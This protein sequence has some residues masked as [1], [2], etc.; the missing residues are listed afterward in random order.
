MASQS[1]GF[2]RRSAPG[3]PLPSLDLLAQEQEYKRLNAELEAKTADLI[4][5]AEEAIRDQHE[6]QSRPCSTLCKSCEEK[7]DYSIRSPLSSE[8]I[9][10]LHPETKNR[11]LNS[12]PC[13]C[14]EVLIPLSHLPGP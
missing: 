7:D 13:A 1:F 5:Q 3:T 9:V 8:G 11:G 4:Q 12:G 2:R 14:Q 10:H 6:A